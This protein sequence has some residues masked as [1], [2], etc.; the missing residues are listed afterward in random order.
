MKNSWAMR[1]AWTFL[2]AMLFSAAL[3]DLAPAQTSAQTPPP[4][5]P[6]VAGK[7]EAE[8]KVPTPREYDSTPPVYT[9]DAKGR[10]D[11]FRSLLIRSEPEK[12]EKPPGIAGMLVA[13]LELQGTIRSKSGWSAMLRGPDNRAY[14]VKKGTPVFD[15]EVTDVNATEVTFRQNVNDPNDPKPFRDVVKSISLQAKR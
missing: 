3:C 9:Y 2:A 5:Q 1:R 11:P 13:E 12:R 14:L 4:S 7:P 8:L 10:R 15:G 6:P